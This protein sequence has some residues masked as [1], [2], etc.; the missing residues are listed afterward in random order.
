MRVIA[1]EKSG[2]VLR[3]PRGER[4]RPTADRVKES[5][6]AILMPVLPGAVVLDLFAGS[7][8]LS[9]E[10]LSRGAERAVLVEK[11][12]QAITC[13]R[14]NL[15]RTAL[16]RSA[17]LMFM[18]V[19]RALRLLHRQEEVFDLVL[20]DPPYDRG[21]VRSTLKAVGAGALI[22]SDGMVVIEHSRKEE[23]P[24]CMTNFAWARQEDY[25]DTRVTFLRRAFV[26]GH[27]SM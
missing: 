8:G 25:G 23:I 18:S 14:E 12:P 24:R 27:L 5:I 19:D 13:I 6:F 15:N 20:M 10:A 21:Y 1:G 7:G 17:K 26:H 4:S 9:I 2:H 11:D 16:E 22:R 3:A